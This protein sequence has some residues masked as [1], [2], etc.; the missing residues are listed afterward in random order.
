M[1]EI[2]IHPVALIPPRMTD[3][4]KQELETSIAANGLLE[5]IKVLPEGYCDDTGEWG[6]AIIDGAERYWACLMAGVD[7]EF[8][9]FDPCG[10]SIEDCVREW[11]CTRRHLDRGQLAT[12]AAAL[13]DY[14]YRHSQIITPRR[15]RAAQAGVSRTTMARADRVVREAPALAKAV[16]AGDVTLT[17]AHH[18]VVST[19]EVPIEKDRFG[20]VIPESIRHCF[21]RE[22][23]TLGRRVR[24]FAKGSRENYMA[25]LGDALNNV[26]MN[27]L[28]YHWDHAGMENAFAM[29]ESQV[30][31]DVWEPYCV[32]PVCGGDA[33]TMGAQCGGVKA[34]CRGQGW[35]TKNALKLIPPQ[36]R[37]VTMTD[38]ERMRYETKVGDSNANPKS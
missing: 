1:R 15:E 2:Q 36:L 10:K 21:T 35:V 9:V 38:A 4:E 20:T 18:E 5:P 22:F 28:A 13:A 31:K 11:S 32:C 26:P 23:T 30:A 7:P 12:T 33:P 8:V 25:L 34:W 27:P 19:P 14:K 6:G 3:E 37:L 17:E 29:I 24:G 16:I